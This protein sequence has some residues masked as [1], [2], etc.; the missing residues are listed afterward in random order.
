MS[1]QRRRLERRIA[2]QPPFAD[3]VATTTCYMCACR[4]GIRVHKLDGEP[5]YIEGNRNHPVNRGVLCA[6]GA[7]GLLN[8][9]SPARLAAP[10]KRVGPRGENAF[11]AISWDQ[12][13]ELAV[14]WLRPIRDRDPRELAFFTGRDQSQALTG[15]WAAEFGTPNY[16]SHGGFCSVNMAAA[17]LY[18]TGGSFWEFGEPDWERCAYLMLFGVAEDHAS[19]PLKMGLARLKERGAKIVSVNPVRTGYSAIADEWLGITPG[20]DGLFVMALCHELLASG[21]VDLDYLMRYTNAPWLVVEAPGEAEDGMF[22]RDEEGRPLVWDRRLRRARSGD[23]KDLAPAMKGEVVLPDGRRAR[24]VFE[25][26]ARRC[27]EPRYAPT[28]VAESTGIAAATVR[29]IAAELARA[30]FES[31]V[32][33][34]EPWTDSWG[35][36]HEKTVGRPVAMHAM[37]GVSAHVNGFHGCRAIHVLQILLGSVDTP[38]GHRY[39]PPFPRHIPC[40]AKPTGRPDQ[41][42]ACQ[43]MPGLPLGFPAGPEDLLVDRDGRPV[44][45]DKAYSWEAPLAIH[46]MMH[47]VIANAW[48]GD[49]YPIDTLFLYMANMAWNSAM[50]VPG[51]LAMLTDRD[52]ETGRYRIPHIIYA[53]AYQSE[54][55]A[56]AD[57]VLPDT[58]Y[59]ERWDAMSLLDRPISD[60]DAAADAIRRP[61]CRPRRDVRP[62]QDVLLDLGHRLA[63]TGLTEADG[64]AMFPGGYSDYLVHHM[65]KPGVGTLAGWRGR[66]GGEDGKGAANPRQLDAY[67]DHDCHWRHEFAPGER[68]YKFANAGYL[69]TATGLGLIDHDGPV[70]LQLYSE[71]LQRFRRAARGHGPVR[72]PPRERRRIAEF[73]DP[74]PLWYAPFEPAGEEFPLHAVTQRPMAMYHAW[75]SQNAWLRQIHGWNRLFIGHAAARRYG[76][77]DGDWAWMESRHGRIKVLVAVMAGVN[78]DTVWTWNAVGKRSG[79]WALDA[80]ASEARK[81]FLLNHLIDHL[82]PEGE[83]GFRFPNADPVTGQAAWYDLHVRLEKAAPGDGEHAFRGPGEPVFATL[84]RGV[85]SAPAGTP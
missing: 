34:D 49:P 7:A 14:S 68:F 60:P 35:R 54:M 18:T 79:A 8:H 80:N 67:I 21:R 36:R 74:L 4:C 2:D 20:T 51:T 23:A 12:A 17:G 46:G 47:T 50:N 37:R 16:A 3:E 5:V 61:V 31:D 82:L 53:D 30:A 63:L 73:C 65:R 11:E 48:K 45:I 41:I 70:V 77:A 75:G 83:D 38:G 64:S 39:R 19:N 33:V 6:K 69:A 62:F 76:L 55:V 13:L 40:S 72:P 85:F 71:E 22:A 29:R 56:Y 15:W 52:A 81:G 84:P 24:P 1:D 32:S 78:P 66:D 25:L 42:V 9:R 43:A 44:R 26:L 58:T 28:A 10:L 27:L 57:L 59:L